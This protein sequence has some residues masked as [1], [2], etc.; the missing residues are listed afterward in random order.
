M[1]EDNL[2]FILDKNRDKNPL[3]LRNLLKEQLQYLI[4]NFIYNSKYAEIF[5]FKGGTAL[6]FC[7]EL[8]RLS[9][10]LD[11]D[12][13][14]YGDFD[15]NEFISEIKKYFYVKLK[16]QDLNIKIS[17]KSKI[18]YLK[19]P[20]LDKIKFPIRSNKPSENNLFVRIDLSS[21]KGKNF[22]KEI[23]L[24]STFDFSF[25]IKRYSIEDIFAGKIAAILSRKSFEGKIL[26]P[27]FKGRDYFDIFW[28][29]G[30]GYRP[31]LKYLSTI[32]PYK[33][34]LLLRRDLEEKLREAGL[35]KDILERD[36]KPF[37]SEQKF[38]KDF[39][40]NFEMLA[41]NFIKLF[42]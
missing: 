38:V 40:D 16:Y 20:I 9:E 39:T 24:K 21:I 17:G 1:I 19:F 29:Q 30:K 41:D 37:F 15:F 18:I 22:K 36:L 5:L 42:K 25:I 11:F 12:V 4:L 35:R 26:K 27:R 34:T 8:P 6:R 2:R 32:I 23:T 33:S 3:Y 7:F 31:N 28:L 10:D 14:D 13:K